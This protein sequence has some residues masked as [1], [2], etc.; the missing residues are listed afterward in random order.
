MNEVQQKC[1]QKQLLV[2]HTGITRCRDSWYDLVLERLHIRQ[3]ARG[4]A[5]VDQEQSSQ[6]HEKTD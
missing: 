5:D 4:L 6:R 1:S 2:Q 3:P